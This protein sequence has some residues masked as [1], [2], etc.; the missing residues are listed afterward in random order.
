MQTDQKHGTTLFPII[1][2]CFMGEAL[3]FGGVRKK[4]AMLMPGPGKAV[5]LPAHSGGSGSGERH[6]ELSPGPDADQ[7]TGAL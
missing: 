6:G 1:E 7:L 2:E 3:F 5:S 4:S